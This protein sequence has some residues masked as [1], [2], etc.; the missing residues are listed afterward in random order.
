V[1]PDRRWARSLPST[2]PVPP[3]PAPFAGT[4]PGATQERLAD[5]GRVAA[6]MA[7]DFSN[8]LTVIA[9]CTDLL[10]AQ[11]ELD[12]AGREQLRLIRRETER[13]ASMIWQILDYAQRGPMARAPV[14]LAV[15]IEELVPVLR[16]T[17][18]PEVSITFHADDA[19]HLVMGDAARLD[20]ILSNLA[21]NAAD[22]ISGTGR[23]DI[24]LDSPEVGWVRVTFSDT[25]AGIPPEVLPQIFEPF[26]STK[27]PGH[28]T[29]LGLSQVQSLISQHGGRVTVSTVLGEG[30]EVEIWIPALGQPSDGDGY[31]LFGKGN[32]D[33]GAAAE[34]SSS[35]ATSQ[36]GR[37]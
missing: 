28:G 1:A 14:D 37:R 13:G 12:E 26:F 29:G 24:G 20:Q 5:I 23:I 4:I 36:P 17:Q 7:H 30:T 35:L 18:A 16:R 31:G 19:R 8:I 25:G 32:D 34:S 3:P 27:P 10:G 6:G 22:A 21:T 33:V 15:L 9:L 11:S 2:R